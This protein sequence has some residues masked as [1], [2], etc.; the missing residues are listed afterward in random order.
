MSEAKRSHG[1]RRGFE[2]YLLIT[3][4]LSLLHL[5]GELTGLSF[6]GWT[7][8][9]FAILLNMLVAAVLVYRSAD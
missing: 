3:I 4:A 6:P 8:I 1:R 7:L 2:A 9:Q 5:V